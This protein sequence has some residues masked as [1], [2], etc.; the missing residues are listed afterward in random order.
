[1]GKAHERE[2]KWRDAGDLYRNYAK[3][4]KNADRKAEAYVRLATVRHQAE[5]RQGSGRRARRRGVR[6]AST[7]ACLGADGKY[8]RRAC[9]LHAGR[10]HPRALRADRDRRRHQE[11]LGAAQAED[12]ALEAGRQRLPRLRE[13][14]RRRV[15]DRR[16][17]PD[18]PHLRVVR[19][20]LCA[21]RR[22]PPISRTP[23]KERTSSRS[24]SS[25]FPSKR[26]ASRPT[27]AAGR[28]RSSSAS[29]TAG[30]RRCAKRSGRLNAELY[31]P[32]KEIGFEIRS[33]AP[34]RLP[35]LIGS[36]RRGGASAGS[37]LL[38]SRKTEGRSERPAAC[39]AVASAGRAAAAARR[40]RSEAVVAGHG[41]CGAAGGGE[42]DLRR[43]SSPRARTGASAPSALMREAIAID[44]NLWEA[45]YDLGVL[46]AQGGDLAG[47]EPSLE[48]AHKLSPNAE[49]IAHR[50]RR[51]AQA[52]RRAEAKRPTACKFSWSSIPMPKMRDALTSS[53]CAIRVRSTLPSRR[54]ARR[55]VASAGDAT[56]LCRA[57][58]GRSSPRASAIRP[59]CW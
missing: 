26:R 29:S 6:S 22:R 47:A 58:A 18:W 35:P 41:A 1:M 12:R 32:L 42:D 21:T 15:V 7:R 3:S 40:R 56:A 48:R 44:P 46:L 31:P 5:Q 14:G 49:E 54:R 2:K 45:H 8:C 9:A 50:A 23:T 34:A 19:Q 4:A 36:P 37:T 16:A 24:T 11:A 10:A 53:R 43:P 25:S 30:P 20:A 57:R 13:H 39:V 51:S 59:S 17:L 38:R 28:R 52:A 33:S 55:C 27:R